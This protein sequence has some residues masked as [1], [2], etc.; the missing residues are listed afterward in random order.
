MSKDL[1]FH[2]VISYREGFGW[3]IAADTEDA[4]FTD[5]TIYDWNKG[6]SYDAWFFAYED[7]DDP[8]NQAIADLDTAHH[9]VLLSALSR[10]NG[11]M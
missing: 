3:N 8:E 2:Y 9:S 11:E 10:M 4:L 6:G 5:G 7:S 1:E